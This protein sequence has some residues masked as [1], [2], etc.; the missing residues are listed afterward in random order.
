MKDAPKPKTSSLFKFMTVE[1][2]TLEEALALLSL[3]REIIHPF[4]G[5]PIIISNGPF[6]PYLK[7]TCDDGPNLRPDVGDGKLGSRYWNLRPLRQDCFFEADRGIPAF[8]RN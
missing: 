3:P 7:H 5:N 4:C 8:L 2:V 6:G 1:D